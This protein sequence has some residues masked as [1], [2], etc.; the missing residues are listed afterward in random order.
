MQVGTIIQNVQLFL[1]KFFLLSYHPVQQF[2]NIINATKRSN[3]Q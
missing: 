3:N 1:F 2:S